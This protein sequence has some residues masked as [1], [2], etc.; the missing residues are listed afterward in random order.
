MSTN[1]DAL[2]MFEQKKAAIGIAGNRSVLKSTF[3]DSIS[4]NPDSKKS[5]SDLT[6]SIDKNRRPRDS[7]TPSKPVCYL[8]LLLIGTCI[9][10]SS[11]LCGFAG[12]FTAF[13]KSNGLLAHLWWISIVGTTLII[14]GVKSQMDLIRD[15]V[16]TKKQDGKVVH[17]RVRRRHEVIM[18][19]AKRVAIGLIIS[20]IMTMG[21][22]YIILNY[23]YLLTGTASGSH[24]AAIPVIGTDVFFV[25]FSIFTSIIMLTIT[26]L[27]LRLTQ[28]E[29]ITYQAAAIFLPA[30]ICSSLVMFCASTALL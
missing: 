17:L 15:T 8:T 16:F 9:G 13:G 1:A 24:P 4:S 3:S 21:L 18:T 11:G 26:E 23:K 28:K 14:I 5:S 27:S 2:A 10:I 22:H 12:A 6:S 7:R 25:L 30:A 19:L 29:G 20:T